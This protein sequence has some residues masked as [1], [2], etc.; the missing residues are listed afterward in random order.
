MSTRSDLDLL[1]RTNNNVVPEDVRDFALNVCPALDFFFMDRG[2]ATSCANG[3]KVRARSNKD[4][5]YRLDAIKLWDKATGFANVDIDWDFEVIKGMNP[6]M[7]TLVS[8]GPIPSKSEA[9]ASKAPVISEAHG[10]SR[11]IDIGTHPITIIASAALI[12]AGAT[13]GVI[14]QTR[15]IP[16]QEEVARL[17]NQAKELKEENNSLKTLNKNMAN[18][19][20]QMD[21]QNVGVVEEPPPSQEALESAGA[22]VKGGH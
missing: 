6:M 17:E 1:L 10:R 4:L 16:L 15:I 18:K 5:V 11:W 19:A 21:R 9:V 22:V 13:F 12:T 2:V 20:L 14:Y 8:M 3:S 7:T